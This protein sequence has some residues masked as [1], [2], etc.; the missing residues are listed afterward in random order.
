MLNSFLL[1]GSGLEIHEHYVDTGG[2][3]DHVFARSYLLGY[4]FVPRIRDLADRRRIERALFTPDWL[5]SKN[6]RLRCL[7]RLNKSE[8]RHSLAGSLFTQKQGRMTDRPVENQ[9]F[10][11][12]G[13]SFVTAAMV[14]WN[15]LYMGLAV[16]HLRAAGSC[17]RTWCSLAV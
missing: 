16:S 6:L 17:P 4:R 5:E 3:T 11:T 15:T 14:C 9:E 7:S 8:A 13:L 10:L 2:T 12:S 1:H